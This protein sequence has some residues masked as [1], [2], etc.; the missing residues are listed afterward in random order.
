METG[1][2]REVEHRHLSGQGTVEICVL[3]YL[4]KGYILPGDGDTH[5]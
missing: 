2:D 4:L 3:L 1:G 5:L